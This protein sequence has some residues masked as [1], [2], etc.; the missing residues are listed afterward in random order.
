MSPS[1][2]VPHHNRAIMSSCTTT[3]LCESAAMSRISTFSAMVSTTSCASLHRADALTQQLLPRLDTKL[4]KT[5][6]RIGSL[7]MNDMILRSRTFCHLSWVL[8]QAACFDTRALLHRKTFLHSLPRSPMSE[9]SPN[10]INLHM[11]GG[12]VAHVRYGTA[13]CTCDE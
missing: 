11:S 3:S 12:A 13:F 9:P 10:L 8:L 6:H 7:M 4:Y 1:H 5:A 2:N